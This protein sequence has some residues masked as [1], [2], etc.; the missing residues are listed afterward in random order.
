MFEQ[1]YYVAEKLREIESGRI[2]CSQ[3]VAPP[4]GKPALA[5]LARPV[6][7]ALHY[8][9]HRLE[10]WAAAAGEGDVQDLRLRER[11]R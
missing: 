10:S 2:L 3:A 8:M 9:G 6:G 4:H 5:P 1:S 11:T 7:R